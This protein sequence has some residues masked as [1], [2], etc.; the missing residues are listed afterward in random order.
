MDS[1]LFTVLIAFSYAGKSDKKYQSFGNAIIIHDNQYDC[2]N[3]MEYTITDSTIYI[4]NYAEE[5][6]MY[7]SGYMPAPLLDKKLS[8]TKRHIV[9]NFM[10]HFPFDSL[11]T[12]Y[13][14]GAKKSCDSLRQIYIEINWN[15]KKKNIQI[16][17]CYQKNVGMLL[18]MINLLIPNDNSHNPL[19]NPDMLR[20]DYTAGSFQC[21]N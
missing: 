15:G 14:S 16:E 4:D 19:Y 1:F 10:E 2:V 13:I 9:E 8:K 11:K 6:D 5:G 7:D 12:A 3:S 20:F 18:D 17:D 21:K